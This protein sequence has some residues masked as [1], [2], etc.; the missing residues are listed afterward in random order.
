MKYAIVSKKGIVENVIEYDGKSKL[1]VKGE[2]VK[3]ADQPID[4]GWLH[5]DGKF[6]APKS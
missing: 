2:L 3:V 4:I 5:K 6:T 1:S